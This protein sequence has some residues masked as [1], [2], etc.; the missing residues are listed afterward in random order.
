[1]L[2]CVLNKRKKQTQRWG[3]MSTVKRRCYCTSD[4]LLSNNIDC[5]PAA[6]SQPNLHS[7]ALKEISIAWNSS[8]QCSRG[9]YVAYHFRGRVEHAIYFQ[10][11]CNLDCGPETNVS[12]TSGQGVVRVVSVDASIFMYLYRHG[13]IRATWLLIK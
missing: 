8:R 3:Y 6:P 9:E 12:A 13:C 4:D 10:T 1:M 5:S 2:L 7:A 11:R